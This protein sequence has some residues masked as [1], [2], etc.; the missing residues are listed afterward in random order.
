MAIK[1]GDSPEALDQILRA[2]PIWM[3]IMMKD[4]NYQLTGYWIDWFTEENFK[5]VMSHY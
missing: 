4:N 3:K 1:K 5:K 2:N